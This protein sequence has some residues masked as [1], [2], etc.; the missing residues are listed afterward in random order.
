M[1]REDAFKLLQEHVKTDRL[2]RHSFA[3]EGAMIAYAKKL[4]ENEDRW[5]LLGLL[6]DI[7]YEK[8]PEEHPDFAPK[9]L[10]ETDLGDDFI[11]SILSHGT[12]SPYPRD[13]KERQCLHAVDEMASF[14]IAVALMR[15]T[16]F[17][18]LKAKSVKKKMKDKRFAAAV[19]REELLTSVES[20]GTEFNEHIDI[21][22]NGLIEEEKMIN[23]DGYTLL[24]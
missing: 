17:E 18:G 24:G 10:S 14:I 22:V 20:L 8:F 1:N 16:R 4:G 13:S 9:L 21:I 12:N 7:D 2:L 23:A 3:V 5:G 19:D 15:P 11:N 6:H